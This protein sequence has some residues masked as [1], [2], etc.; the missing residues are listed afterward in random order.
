MTKTEI[1]G[2]YKTNSGF[3]VR[4]S[5]RDPFSG[6]PVE[7]SKNLNNCF[8]I[9]EAIRVKEELS[10]SLKEELSEGSNNMRDISKS[11][12]E[13]YSKFYQ[14]YR[15]DNGIAKQNVLLADDDT[16]NKFILPH[17]GKVKLQQITKRGV[18][19]FLDKLREQM[20]EYGVP[21]SKKTYMNAWSLFKSSMRCA[22]RLGFV[23]ENVCDLVVP[24]FPHAK[25]EREK[26]SLSKEDA[27]KLLNEAEKQDI[28]TY[29]ML[30][31]LC[32]LGLR[33]AEVKALTWGDLDFSNNCIRINK[34]HHRGFTHKS[35]KN[36]TSFN[37]PMIGLVRGAAEKYFK[38]YGTNAKPNDLLFPS[39]RSN[40][41][42][43][44]SYIRKVIHKCCDN[45]GI[46]RISPHD[47]RRSANTILLL[48][49]VS[50]EIC[51]KVLNHKSLEMTS[52]YT[53]LSTKQA[54]T[55][56]EGVWS[57]IKG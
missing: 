1:A 31:C 29:F 17:I 37:S 57:E 5:K 18:Y 6:K 51:R 14:K 42:M 50:P 15:L 56:L 12:Y 2:I 47:C 41:Y 25:P 36:G 49:H 27:A 28:R 23:S 22:Y 33:S 38:R 26:K 4:V 43:D 9:Q 10:K 44:N 40:T 55:V 24:N 45:A 3:M 30:C 39:I 8:D 21:Y 34:S 16:F 35:T 53:Q 13:A 54:E 48:S 32:I 7:K 52:H 19:F 20:N 46:D 11:S